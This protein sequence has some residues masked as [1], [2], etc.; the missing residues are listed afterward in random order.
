LKK[1]T[2]TSIN[3]KYF[4]ILVKN[5]LKLKNIVKYKKRWGLISINLKIKW[6]KFSRLGQP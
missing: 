2:N 3:D 4:A 1:K 6:A 5:L